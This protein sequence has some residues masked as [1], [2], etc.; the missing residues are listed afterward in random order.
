MLEKFIAALQEALRKVAWI[1]LYFFQLFTD[2]TFFPSELLRIKYAHPFFT[3]SQ[4]DKNSIL[5][6]QEKGSLICRAT[7]AKIYDFIRS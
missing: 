4:S 7:S 6:V 3:K 2:R 5:V 1:D